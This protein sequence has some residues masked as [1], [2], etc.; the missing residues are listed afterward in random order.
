MGASRSDEDE[1]VEVHQ[2]NIDRELSR[3]PCST[4]PA[5]HLYRLSALTINFNLHSNHR[6]KLMF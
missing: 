6:Q 5:P 1:L 4:S 3:S 2:T